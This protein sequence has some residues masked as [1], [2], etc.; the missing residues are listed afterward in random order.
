MTL[1][2]ARCNCGCAR[3]AATVLS[4]DDPDGRREKCPLLLTTAAFTHREIRHRHRHSTAMDDDDD[5]QVKQDGYRCA[6][7]ALLLLQVPLV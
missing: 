4:G 3:Q 2:S 6:A 1:C 7:K 5:M